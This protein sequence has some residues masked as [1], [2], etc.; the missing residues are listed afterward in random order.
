VPDGWRSLQ[1][2]TLVG[3]ARRALARGEP[4]ARAGGGAVVG[5]PPASPEDAASVRARALAAGMPA[6]AADALAARWSDLP[7]A[8]RAQVATPLVPA[9]GSEELRWGEDPARQVDQTTCGSAVLV[10]LAAAGDP[11][12]AL[13]LATGDELPGYVPPEVLFLGRTLP[14]ALALTPA[15][16][17]AALQRTVKHLTNLGPPPWPHS[18]GTPP[19]GAAR[20]ARHGPVRFRGEMVDDADRPRTADQ[21]ARAQEALAA[22][23]PVPLYV[24]GDLGGGLAHAVPRHVVLLVG[25][26]GEEVLVYEPGRGVVVPLPVERL[27][28][29]RGPE[30]ALGGWTHGAWILLPHQ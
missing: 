26:H 6:R 12:L 18:L 10:M 7:P 23:V 15:R 30:R 19:W 3:L 5:P 22:G 17:F 28:A 1:A 4:G 27:A 14:G 20:V 25:A 2:T 9:P 16:R 24:Q 11:A 21:L 29:P 13:W 8:V